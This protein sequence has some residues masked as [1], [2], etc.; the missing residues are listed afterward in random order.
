MVNIKWMK[1]S[2]HHEL[3]VLL[4]W[5]ILSSMENIKM[6]THTSIIWGRFGIQLF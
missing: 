1:N 6:I 4:G 5:D 3:F 2:F